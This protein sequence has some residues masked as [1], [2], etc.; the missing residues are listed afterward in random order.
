MRRGNIESRR[1]TSLQSCV[2]G[3]GLIW[4]RKQ[5]TSTFSEITLLLCKSWAL[6]HHITSRNSFHN[7]Y[8]NYRYI[9]NTPLDIDLHWWKEQFKKST[10][11]VGFVVLSSP[12]TVVSQHYHDYRWLEVVLQR[13]K[14]SHSDGQI[15]P[16]EYYMP[17]LMQ[18]R[19]AKNANF[20]KISF[21]TA[22]MRFHPWNQAKMR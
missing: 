15:M 8:L 3:L 12:I 21:K 5:A 9:V 19:M 7:N 6:P 18:H 4:R 2:S 20:S 22:K 13:L 14:S 16:L 11:I 1:Q 17:A 10:L